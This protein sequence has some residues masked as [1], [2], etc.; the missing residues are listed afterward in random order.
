MGIL[1]FITLALGL[2]GLFS[3]NIDFFNRNDDVT[4]EEKYIDLSKVA[5]ELKLYLENQFLNS[6]TT[7]TVTQPSENDIWIIV[8]NEEETKLDI[9]LEDKILVFNYEEKNKEIGSLIFNK[10]VSFIQN[11]NFGISETETLAT[12]SSN[13][14]ISFTVATQGVESIKRNNKYYNKLDVSHKISLI[15][16]SSQAI[17]VSDLEGSRD[18]LINDGAFQ[19]SK[20][21]IILY[22]VSSP[23]ET[24]I[25]IME[26]DIFTDNAYKS[27]IAALTIVLDSTQLENFKNRYPAIVSPDSFDN[28][29]IEINPDLTEEETVIMQDAN[30]QL[31][32]VTITK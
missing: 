5:N 20:G 15:S 24:K 2:I 18:L 22:K 21:N 17:E 28:Y 16:I 25:S 23:T 32:R 7:V 19:T 27:L 26:K 4:E 12:L 11:E 29:I 31:I 3:G 10:I 9:T 1:C 13:E 30:Y 8:K 6:E 14:F